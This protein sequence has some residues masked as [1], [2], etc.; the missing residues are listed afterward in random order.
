MIITKAAEDDLLDFLCRKI[1]NRPDGNFG[2]GFPRVAVDAGRNSGEGDRRTF[3]FFG[4]LEAV[5]VARFQKLGFPVKPVPIHRARR[6]DDVLRRKPEPGSDFSL[7]RLASVQGNARAKE[8]RT[9]RPVDGAVHAAATQKRTVRRIH[10]GIYRKRS[11]VSLDNFDINHKRL[12]GKLNK[13]SP[14]EN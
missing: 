8:F 14:H 2:C 13:K 3:V 9:R 5:P 7:A 6:M 1:P 10:D 11:D 4:K 12:K